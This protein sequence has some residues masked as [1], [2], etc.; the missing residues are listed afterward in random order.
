[1]FGKSKSSKHV[2]TKDSKQSVTGRELKV[3]S[4][5]DMA[6]KLSGQQQ[7]RQSGEGRQVCGHSCRLC[8]S[9]GL[10]VIVTHF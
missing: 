2:S 3:K 1:M 9:G 7:V 4:Q 6:L 10:A 8:A 5:S